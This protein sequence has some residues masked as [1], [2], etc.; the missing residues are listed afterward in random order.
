M[1]PGTQEKVIV[2]LITD[3]IPHKPLITVDSEERMLVSGL[4]DAHLQS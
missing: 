3:P 1:A 2:V 4:L